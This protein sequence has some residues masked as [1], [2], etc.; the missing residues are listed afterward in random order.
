M[1]AASGRNTARSFPDKEAGKG[2][3]PLV[4]Y[5]VQQFNLVDFPEK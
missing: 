3:R 2:S 4:L 5:F 1:L